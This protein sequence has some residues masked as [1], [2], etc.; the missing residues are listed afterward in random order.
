MA[1]NGVRKTITTDYTFVNGTTNRYV[2]FN[3]ELKVDDQIRMAGYSSAKKID[4]VKTMTKIEKKRARRETRRQQEGQAPTHLQRGIERE[5]ER[6]SEG[7][8]ERERDRERKRGE[9][10]IERRCPF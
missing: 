6:E 10:E 9:A 5:R 2:K 3:K 4:G 7:E 1:V 8:S